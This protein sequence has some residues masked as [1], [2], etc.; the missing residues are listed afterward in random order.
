MA[1]VCISC[2]TH[3][4]PPPLL[5]SYFPPHPRLKSRSILQVYF[6]ICCGGRAEKSLDLSSI[7]ERF[8]ALKRSTSVFLVLFYV[9]FCVWFFPFPLTPS[10]PPYFLFSSPFTLFPSLLPLFSSLI[11][12]SLPSS[13]SPFL[14][15][16]PFTFPFFSFFSPRGGGTEKYTPLLDC[17]L[18]FY[19]SFD[20]ANI[21]NM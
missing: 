4:P 19:S 6:E 2:E 8:G 12:F 18:Y 17:N 20:M 1:G 5:E 9:S 14:F 21:E 13:S 10:L 15:H 3:I 7:M 16:F 11:P